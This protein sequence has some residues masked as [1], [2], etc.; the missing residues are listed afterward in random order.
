MR[1]NLWKKPRISFF[2]PAATSESVAEEGRQLTSFSAKVSPSGPA[3]GTRILPLQDVRAL[4]VFC[5]ILAEI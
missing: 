3:Q 4:S 2:V 1:T 5:A